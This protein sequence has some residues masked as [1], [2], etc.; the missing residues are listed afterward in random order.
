M[1]TEYPTSVAHKAGAKASAFFVPREEG[2]FA[3]EDSLGVLLLAVILLGD[4]RRYLF[5]C[6]LARVAVVGGFDAFWGLYG[7]PRR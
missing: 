7:T 5:W 6:V 4:I 3:L 1:V 2:A